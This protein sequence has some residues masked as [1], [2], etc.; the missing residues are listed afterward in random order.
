MMTLSQA[1]AC[2]KKLSRPSQAAVGGTLPFAALFNPVCPPRQF[3]PA[4]PGVFTASAGLRA[5]LR[6]QIPPRNPGS[7]PAFSLRV[8]YNPHSR[9]ALCI[10]VHWILI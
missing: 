5:L 8:F 2:F 7:S 9:P 4:A 1:K 10:A 3:F 6:A